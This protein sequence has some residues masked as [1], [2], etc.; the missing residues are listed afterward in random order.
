[1][2]NPV[3][4]QAI[5]GLKT[6]DAFT[7]SRTFKKEETEHFGDITRD[8]NPVHYDL[9]WAKAKGF[10]RLICHGLLVGSMI[11]E[12]GGQVGWLATGM[13]F[14]FIKPVYFDDTITCTITITKIEESGKAEAEAFFFNASGEK[15]CCSHLTGRLPL[16]RER[17]ILAQMV[18][19]GDPTNRLS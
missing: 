19:A 16:P 8:Y 7:Y 11:C 2:T 4:Q 17:M 6:G 13:K 15:V 3:R 1:M 14:K 18:E 12:F 5:D 10:D 9:R